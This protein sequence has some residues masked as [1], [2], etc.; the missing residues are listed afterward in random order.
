MRVIVH[1]S[2]VS[3]CH[4]SLYQA[5]LPKPSDGLV[6]TDP[7]CLGKHAIGSETATALTETKL[8][9]VQSIQKVHYRQWG[10]TRERLWRE[11]RREGWRATIL[12]PEHL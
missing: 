3:S 6:S 12:G 11:G 5:K 2:F 1:P 10:R 9:L 7:D 8:I 4:V